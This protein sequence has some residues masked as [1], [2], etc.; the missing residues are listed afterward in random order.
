M[1]LNAIAEMPDDE[2]RAFMA[3]T[4]N[5]RVA[6]KTLTTIANTWNCVW[7]DLFFR[8]VT[9]TDEDHADMQTIAV[10]TLG[11]PWDEPIVLRL[12]G[13]HAIAIAQERG[14]A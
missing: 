13:P 3:P 8:L 11:R 12:T 14:A 4:A 5:D 10:A 1:D 6:P 2:Y 7:R 9:I